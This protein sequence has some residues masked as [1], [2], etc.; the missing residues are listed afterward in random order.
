MAVAW[1]SADYS[2]STLNPNAPPF[3]PSS[4]QRAAPDLFSSSPRRS[5]PHRL[6][7]ASGWAEDYHWIDHRHHHRGQV[8]TAP[9]AFNGGH[10]KTDGEEEEDD[11][12]ALLPET[13]E[14]EDF[15]LGLQEEAAPFHTDAEQ[16]KRVDALF[17]HHKTPPRL[18]IMAAESLTTREGGRVMSW[19]AVE[20]PRQYWEEAAARSQWH[21]PQLYSPSTF[22]DFSM[23]A[24]AN[25]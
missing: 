13:F 5:E 25:Q 15:S 10:G 3:I 4:F 22:L 7:K 24:S 8:S 21:N 2:R 1:T 14:V 19:S 12:A 18:D 16:H 17:L 20:L 9:A 23:L 11:I 6:L